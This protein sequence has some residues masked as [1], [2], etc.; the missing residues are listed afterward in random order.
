MNKDYL[1]NARIINLFQMHSI[2]NM[3]ENKILTRVKQIGIYW[4]NS[5]ALYVHRYGLQKRVLAGKTNNDNVQDKHHYGRYSE[6]INNVQVKASLERQSIHL[7]IIR[8]ML[9]LASHFNNNISD[10][11]HYPNDFFKI[12]REAN[13]TP[14]LQHIH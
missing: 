3:L 7:I 5:K 10:W 6:K 13:V 2:W 8:I 9:S 4:L 12:L 14:T 11:C 1:D